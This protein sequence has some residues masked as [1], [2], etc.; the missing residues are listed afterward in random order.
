MKTFAAECPHCGCTFQAQESYLGKKGRCSKCGES[1]VVQRPVTKPEINENSS[2]SPPEQTPVST[3][4]PEEVKYI[5]HEQPSNIEGRKKL[6]F[7]ISRNFSTLNILSLVYGVMGALVLI[8][9]VCIGLY[10][11]AMS[12]ATEA[13]SPAG[14]MMIPLSVLIGT[15]LL[16]TRELINVVLAVEENTRITAEAVNELRK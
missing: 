12:L 5:D 7:S 3:T 6:N 14:L 1:F 9:G 11:F 15:T 2:F 13:P 10:L 8:L 16:V 4:P